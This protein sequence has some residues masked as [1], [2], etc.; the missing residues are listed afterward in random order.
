MST[1]LLSTGSYT[2]TDITTTLSTT[3]TMSSNI[4]ETT[5]ITLEYEK[6][7][8]LI[9]CGSAITLVTIIFMLLS[10]ILYKRFRRKTSEMD[11]VIT[12]MPC[13][14]NID[15]YPT[16]GIFNDTMTVSMETETL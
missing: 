9:I 4:S 11:E 2:G 14:R 15:Q 16:D 6:R 3:S 8:V 1:P 12:Q 13:H 5:N 10:Y 7:N